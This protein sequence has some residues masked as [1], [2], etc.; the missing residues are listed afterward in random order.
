PALARQELSGSTG[1]STELRVGSPWQGL[2]SMTSGELMQEL[3]VIGADL[4]EE[5]LP[6]WV[7][8]EIIPEEQ[9]HAQATFCY[10]SDVAKEKAEIRFD[11]PVAAAERMVRAFNPWPIAWFAI[12]G[13]RVKVFQA[14]QCE[15]FRMKNGELSQ[16]EG[17][18]NEGEEL[19]IRREGKRLFLTLV[20][21]SLELLELQLEGKQRGDARDY[22]FLA[23]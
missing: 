15:E 21:G 6:K 19:E 7:A 18:E 11:T 16:A 14:N 22:L 17:S 23:K 12:G 2:R 20:D 1:P 9:D 13:K 3:S 10:Q 8:G 5:I 4:L